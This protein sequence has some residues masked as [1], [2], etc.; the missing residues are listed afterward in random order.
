MFHQEVPVAL[1]GEFAE[2]GSCFVVSHHLK[3]TGLHETSV[4]PMG[5]SDACPCAVTA[6]GASSDP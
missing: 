2:L 5:L 6:G 1:E 4:V 3:S